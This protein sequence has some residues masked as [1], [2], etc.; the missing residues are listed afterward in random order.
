MGLEHQGGRVDGTTGPRYWRSLDEY[1]QTPEFRALLRDEFPSQLENWE[2]PVGRRHFLKLMGASIAL[3]G[4]SGCAYQPP[5]K[6]VPYVKAPDDYIVGKPVFYA[7]AL[8]FGGYGMGVLVESNDHRP[9]KIEGN[10]DHPASLGATDAFGQAELLQMYDPD[11]SQVVLLNGRV[12]AWETFLEEWIP[13]RARKLADK[14][15]GVRLLT[16]T[17]T[18][19]TL[20]DLLDQF[21]KAM[22]E[23]RWHQFEPVGRESSRAGAI[24][25]FGEPVEA[26]HHLDQADVIASFDS[27]FLSWGPGRLADARNWAKRRDPGHEVPN[28]WEANRL[29]VVET[30]TSITGAVADHRLA[31]RPS[32]VAALLRSLAAKLGVTAAGQAS[33]EHDAW[34]D[35]L[36]KDLQAHAGKSLLLVG[37]TQPAEVH[38]LGHAIN[39]KLQNIGKTVTFIERVAA[40]GGEQSGTL[41]ELVKDMQDGAVDTLFILDGNPV[42]EAPA[43]LDIVKALDKVRFGVHVGLFEDETSEHCRWHVPMAH[44]LEGWGDVRAFDGTVTIQQPLI[45]PIFK[46]RPIVEVVKALVEG[47]TTPD[48]VV[49]RDYW[50]KRGLGDDFE[51]GWRKALHSGVVPGTASKVK[52]VT[53]KQETFGGTAST[54]DVPGA[55]EVHFRPDTSIWDGTYANNGWLQEL[56]KQITKLTWDNAAIISPKTATDLNVTTNTMEMVNDMVEVVVQDRRLRLPVWI[57]PGHADGAVTIHL[58]YGRTK[59][60]RVGDGAGFN[61]NSLR[62][63]ATPWSAAGGRVRKV[64]G[65]YRLAT[66]Q[67]FQNIDYDNTGTPLNAE[68]HLVRYA[69]VEHFKKHPKFAQEPDHHLEVESSLY[70]H[71]PEPRR[72]NEDAG[73]GNRWA[74]VINMNTCIGCNACVVACNAENNIPVIGK[75]G[76]LRNRNMHWLRIDRYYESEP[77]SSSKVK[78]HFQPLP[79]MQCEKAPCELVCPFAATVHDSEG[80]NVMIYNRCAGTKFCSNN[81]PYKVRRF[82]YFYYN[83]YESESLMLMRNPDVS[84][85]TRGVM[86]KCTYCLQ[87]LW[88]AK[89]NAE[90]KR[91]DTKVLDGEVVTACAGACP[92]RTITFGNLNDPDSAVAKARKDDRNYGLLVE[93]NTK[94][95]TTYLAKL[96]N[97]NP[98]IKES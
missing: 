33:E 46:G 92:T 16:R 9:T 69:T 34:V 81:C 56:P 76:V 87:R 7:T 41:A 72:Q 88:S 30:M 6:I 22:P 5:E 86:E 53:L 80:I 39:Q 63:T 54:P 70:P 32:Q 2:D 24:L 97:P 78:V 89:I 27:D 28:D 49:V 55:F 12:S 79:C 40:N 11:R 73:I 66:T 67:H 68:R 64:E 8:G 74:M 38:A 52:A 14:G 42:Y 48:R 98:A 75:S 51:A 95:R 45:Q 71:S 44:T 77:D 17:I 90:K 85:R 31:A 1:A 21:L 36:A 47:T 23:A 94:P 50:Q 57:E 93:L 83:D 25:A 58:G 4:A 84:V 29:Y 61:A 62:T 20:A 65:T 96:T 82:G 37:E 3:A 59:A 18:S 15:K 60:G 35:A 43:D 26:V 10:P 19:P 91:G 13:L